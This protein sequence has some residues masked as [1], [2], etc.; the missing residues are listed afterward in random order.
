MPDMVTIAEAA[1]RLKCT[2]SAVY[3]QIKKHGIETEK[4]VVQILRAY[5]TL[6][7]LQHVDYEKLMELQ[8]RPEPAELLK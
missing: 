2:K 3:Q 5:T 6:Q 8:A 4:R 1:D 7:P